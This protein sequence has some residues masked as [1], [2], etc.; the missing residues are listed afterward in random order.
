M[1]ERERDPNKLHGNKYIVCWL[2]GDERIKRKK[3]QCLPNQIRQKHFFD[4]IS[5]L[6]AWQM[7]IKQIKFMIH[8]N[9]NFL[10]HKTKSYLDKHCE[11][12]NFN[13]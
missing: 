8:A 5:P 1:R 6:S 11:G 12:V 4:A 3:W 9:A 10:F 7:H 13:K 2:V